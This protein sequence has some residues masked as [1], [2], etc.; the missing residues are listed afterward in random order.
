[1]TGYIAPTSYNTTRDR[2]FDLHV[3]PEHDPRIQTHQPMVKPYNGWDN[4][5]NAKSGNYNRYVCQS[6]GY[7]Y[8]QAPGVYGKVIEKPNVSFPYNSGKSGP[9]GKSCD[10]C[11]S[12]GYSIKRNLSKPHPF[13]EKPVY[14]E[15]VR[16]RSPYYVDYH[17]NTCFSSTTP[18]QTGQLQPY[19]KGIWP[20]EQGEHTYTPQACMRAFM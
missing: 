20:D 12:P 17:T 1:M 14:E 16:V 5:K 9:D 4:Y 13:V 15:P 8:S 7:G 2:R 11:S 6:E 3:N 18:W 10:T 19:L